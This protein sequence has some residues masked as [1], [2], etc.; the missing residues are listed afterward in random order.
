MRIPIILLLF[1]LISCQKERKVCHFGGMEVSC[2][3]LSEKQS[4]LLPQQTQASS[5]PTP[6][7]EKESVPTPQV[8]PK[9]KPKPKPRAHS[10]TGGEEF[11]LPEINSGV[12]LEIQVKRDGL[13]FEILENKQD[14]AI[15]NTLAGEYEC[16]LSFNA[17][18]M[19]EFNTL[20]D[21][22]KI[23]TSEESLIFL[24]K[25]GLSGVARGVWIRKMKIKQ[26]TYQIVLTIKDDNKI[27]ITKS[28][29]LQ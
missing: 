14:K 27:K 23:T 21:L 26:G 15:L 2:D 19:L 3:A 7:V 18:D 25:E 28:C 17:G 20:T 29:Q 16:D 13:K 5:E 12:E 6:A 22:M 1:I 24:R 4:E 10:M 8:K 9:P 11:L